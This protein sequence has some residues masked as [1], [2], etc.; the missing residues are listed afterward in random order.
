MWKS[1]SS[2]RLPLLK[3]HITDIACA[4]AINQFFIG[5]AE[6]IRADLGT[7]RGPQHVPTPVNLSQLPPGFMLC[8][9]LCRVSE[10][11]TLGLINSLNNKKSLGHD[12]IP[13]LALKL[14]ATIL[15][16]PATMFTNTSLMNGD[17]PQT[18]KL[19]DIAPLHKKKEKDVVNNYRPVALTTAISKLLESAFLKQTSS[20]LDKV[21]A[22]RA[23]TGCPLLS[24]LPEFCPL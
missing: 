20:Y 18:C 1:K 12:C 3:G 9:S 14:G 11:E 16:G 2:G 10:K 5:K 7:D 23:S 21:L 22:A 19:V 24:I 6:R 17:V 8:H 4:E 15:A 13:V